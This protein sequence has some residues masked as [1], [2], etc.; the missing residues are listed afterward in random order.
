M[1][2][3]YF[4]FIL[5][6]KFT[7]KIFLIF[8]KYFYS[9]FDLLTNKFYLNII[10][11]FIVFSEIKELSLV[12]LDF[13]SLIIKYNS[14]DTEPVPRHLRKQEKERTV[15]SHKWATEMK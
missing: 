14:C 13:I 6:Y 9:D 10:I 1:H 4:N 15:S 12:R 11:L 8:L 7:F 2:S 5:L 3:F